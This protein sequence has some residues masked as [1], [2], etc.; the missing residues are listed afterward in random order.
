[1]KTIETLFLFS[2]FFLIFPLIFPFVSEKFRVGGWSNHRAPIPRVRA[3][4][5]LT[6]HFQVTLRVGLAAG[7]F[8]FTD[9]IKILKF[10]KFLFF[11]RKSGNVIHDCRAGESGRIMWTSLDRTRSGFQKAG[12]SQ[13]RMRQGWS[14]I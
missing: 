7:C 11:F 3:C 13:A 2:T 14:W 4:S 12:S 9:S 6:R 5:T 10:G 8:N 1:M